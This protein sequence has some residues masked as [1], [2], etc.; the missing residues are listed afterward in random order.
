MA[1]ARTKE[2][3]I[4]ESARAEAEQIRA[5]LIAKANAEAEQIVERARQEAEAERAQVLSDARSDVANLSI[6]LAERVV[7]A[8]LDQETQRGLVERYI[9]EL[10]SGRT[11]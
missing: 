10:E 9:Q 6:D 7:G 3:E 5:D 11:H 4:L 2:N 8:N 1:E